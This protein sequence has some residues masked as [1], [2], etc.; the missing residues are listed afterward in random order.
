M[1]YICKRRSLKFHSILLWSFVFLSNKNT[2]VADYNSKMLFGQY[3]N[4]RKN[5]CLGPTEKC[6]WQTAVGLVYIVS[7]A[8]LPVM[9][10][11][12]F[13]RMFLKTFLSAFHWSVGTAFSRGRSASQWLTRGSERGAVTVAQFHYRNRLSRKTGQNAFPC[14]FGKG[15]VRRFQIKDSCIF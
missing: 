2:C 5:N 4:N 9:Y 14:Q 3:R 7:R 8:F 11:F 12:P 10:L 15:S 1:H 13:C 6:L